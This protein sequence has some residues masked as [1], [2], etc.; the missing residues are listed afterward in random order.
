MSQTSLTGSIHTSWGPLLHTHLICATFC[1]TDLEYSLSAFC[2]TSKPHFSEPTTPSFL[3]RFF[4]WSLWNHIHLVSLTSQAT[5][6]WYHLLG[7]PSLAQLYV[8]EP[9]GS[10]LRLLLLLS[11]LTLAALSTS[12]MRTTHSCICSPNFSLLLYI[13]TWTSTRPLTSNLSKTE[14]VISPIS[15]SPPVLPISLNSTIT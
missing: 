3:K 6:L 8:L 13:S 4:F 11:T 2:F 1:G 5:P 7:P 15:V 10:A 12:F 9:Q 14:L